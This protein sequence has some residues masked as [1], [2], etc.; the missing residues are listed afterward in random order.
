MTRCPT[1]VEISVCRTPKTLVITAVRIMP[2][3]S[4]VS[5]PVRPWGIAV[6]RISRSRNG[7]ATDTSEEA[8][9]SRPT[10]VSLPR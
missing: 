10:K 1:V 9:T 6:S 3:A 4:S 5:R 8:P 2:S 7:E